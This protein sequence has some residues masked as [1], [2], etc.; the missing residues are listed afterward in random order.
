MFPKGNIHELP[1]EPA[2]SQLYIP[3]PELAL[4][5]RCHSQWAEAKPG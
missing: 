3:G 4:Y 2:R 1:G 5:P